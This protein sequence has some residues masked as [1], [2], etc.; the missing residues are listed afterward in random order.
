MNSG[1]RNTPSWPPG[2]EDVALTRLQR[3][4]CFLAPFVAQKDL[5]TFRQA[6]SVHS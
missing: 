3:H 5:K 4:Y 6:H 1:T 2:A